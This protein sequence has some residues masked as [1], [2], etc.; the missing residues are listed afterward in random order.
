MLK[1]KNKAWVVAVDMGYGHQRAA[2]ALRDLAPHNKIIIAN[3]YP[4][5]N[6]RDKRIWR[7]SREL[8]EF[9][10]KLKPIP[11]LGD[12]I[13][14]LMDHLQA[15]PEFYPRRDLS[16]PI[17]QLSQVYK[18][19]THQGFAR[20]L[21]ETLQK[22]PLPLIT[23]FPVPA[24]AADYFDYPNDI[25]C[26]ICDADISRFWVPPDPKKSRIKYFAPNGR[27][28]ERLK[29]YG[30]REENIFLTG[31]PLPPDLIG[32]P[33][34]TEI[35]KDFPHRLLNLDP[36]RI[37]INQAKKTLL[38]YLGSSAFPKKSN[39]PLTLL[40]S[41][42]GAG[43][44][45]ALAL[46]V[47]K[48]LRSSIKKHQIRFWL[49]A[50]THHELSLIFKKAIADLG[51]FQEMGKWVDVIYTPK[52]DAYFAEFN[53][54]LHETDIIWTKPSEMSFYCGAGLPIIIAPPIGSQED[55]NKIWLQNVGGGIPQLDPRYANEWLFDWINSG[56]LAK[57]AWSGFIQAPTHGT[58]RIEDIILKRKTELKPPPLIV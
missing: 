51:L 41:V 11:V 49:V 2:Y 9:V 25:Y 35:R 52:R 42:G 3:N 34:Y 54:R 5:I 38:N 23:T 46:E 20:D 4:G 14:G 19:I 44:Q 29:L 45:R 53:K 43:A 18:Y 57:A 36:Q 33:N 47:L 24:F 32:G 10:S 50:G 56:G 37:F 48:S 28:V 58:Y 17:W 26:V 22:Y 8:Y 27:V 40:F 15:I 12:W 16:K 55:F 31:F 6:S 13:F 30:V 7:Q 21:I 39:H 1:T